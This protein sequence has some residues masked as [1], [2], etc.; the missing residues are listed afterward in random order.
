MRSHECNSLRDDFSGKEVT[1][2]GWVNRRRDHGGVIFVDLRDRSGLAQIVFV[3]T[4]ESIFQEAEKL[5][6][7]YV[8]EVTGTVQFRPEGMRNAS[9]ATGNVEVLVNALTIHNASET[10]PFQLDDFHQTHEDIRL[11]YRYLDLRRTEMLSHLAFRAKVNQLLRDY[12]TA[13]DFWEIETPLLTKATPEGARD[14]IVPS[15]TQP[16]NFFALPQSPQLFKQLLMMS[17]VERYYQIARCFRDEDLRADRQPEFTQ[18]DIEASFVDEQWIQTTMEDMVR[19]LYKEMLAVDLP[20][21]F[22]RISY[23][24]AMR[25]FGSD[26]PDLRIPLV[27]VDINDLVKSVKFNV[28]AKPANDTNGRVAALR[29]PKGC[30]LTRKQLD[31]YEDFVKIYGAKGLA[32]IRI[33]DKQAGVD[34]LQSPILKFLPDNVIQAILERTQAE[35]GDVIFFGADNAKVVNESLGALRNKLGY[36]HHMLENEWKPVWIYD[37]PMF[38]LNDE[39]SWDPL[40]HPFTAP[41]HLDVDA[42]K[43]DPSAALAKAYDLVINGVE[44]GGGSMRIHNEHLQREIFQLLDITEEEFD[45]KFGF[46]LTALRYGCPPHGGIAFGLDRL[47][48]LMLGVNSI[49]EVIAFPKTQTAKCLL[50]DAPSTVPLKHLLEL[51]VTVKKTE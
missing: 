23:Q 8:I 41:Q 29:L 11:R 46:F 37:W 48:M 43:A 27:L 35:T 1:L 45:E 32:Y 42:M 36:D 22:P 6:S 3:P 9:L 20:N 19:C 47:V 5:R 31:D 25:R 39:G 2:C 14:Y 24:D 10:P 28:F 12:L 26:K 34:G 16:G 21:P 4:C 13:K 40:H 38:E 51:G 7:E 17:G 33:N 15:R 44:V 18:L 50:T 49:R 30:E